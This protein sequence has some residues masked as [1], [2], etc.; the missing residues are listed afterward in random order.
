[1]KKVINFVLKSML[2]C[3]TGVLFAA[4]SSLQSDIIEG[5]FFFLEKRSPFNAQ[6]AWRSAIT[7]VVQEQRIS[8]MNNAVI[9]LKNCALRYKDQYKKSDI[10][11]SKKYEK[12]IEEQLG[13]IISALKIERDST[14][15]FKER[16]EEEKRHRILAEQRLQEWRKQVGML[17]KQATQREDIL[18]NLCSVVRVQGAT[19]LK[20]IVQDEKVDRERIE[21]MVN[22]QRV[23]MM[24][25]YFMTTE[26]SSHD[27]AREKAR[28]AY[29]F[30]GHE[31]YSGEVKKKSFSEEAHAQECSIC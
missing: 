24:I 4:Q 2:F 25:K 3:V 29:P 8:R 18:K 9:S 1:M 23:N 15:L 31:Y 14:Q 17:Q 30:F 5:D 19:I 20:K 6:Y 7:R 13:D 27:Q 28:E 10:A 22:R 26:G 16:A 21:N 12:A 11:A